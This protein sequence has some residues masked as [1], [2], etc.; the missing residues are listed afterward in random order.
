MP[1]ILGEEDWAKWLGEEVANENAL[2]ALLK[3]FAGERMTLWP[4][5]RDVGSVRNE[6][7]RLIAPV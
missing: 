3:P 2:L 4:V 5:G 6:G 7:A 1:V